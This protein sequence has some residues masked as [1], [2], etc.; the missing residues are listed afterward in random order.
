MRQLQLNQENDSEFWLGTGKIY[1]ALDARVTAMKPK[2]C[3]ETCP[4]RT[5]VWSGN[6]V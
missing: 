2:L 6:P 1:E 3:S 4:I 5:T